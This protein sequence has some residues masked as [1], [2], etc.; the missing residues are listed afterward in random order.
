M[1]KKER[2]L[3]RLHSDRYKWLLKN[4]EKQ[5]YYSIDQ[6]FDDAQRY[7]KAIKER[8][9]ICSIGSVSRSGMSR[10]IK[11][12]ECSKG[13]NGHN[14]LNFFVFFKVLGYT[15]TRARDHYFSISGCGMDMIFH[16]N[17]TNI[18]Y[19]HNLG[20]INRP[21]CGDLA[22]MTPTVIWIMELNAT[23][24]NGKYINGEINTSLPYVA[25]KC[26]EFF[27]QGDD[28]DTI[29]SEIHE[30]WLQGELTNEQAFEHW[31]NLYL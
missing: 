7:V 22:Q 8:R 4:I 29:I 6:F 17:Y 23:W 28:A 2:F 15:E 31:I 14:Y 26:P 27:V 21:Q 20:I 1:T 5:N 3:K 24:L 25:V 13:T 18:H 30:I 9:I 11:F 12:L 10:T 16:S 19:L